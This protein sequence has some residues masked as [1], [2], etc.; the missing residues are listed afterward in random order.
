MK[1][2]FLIGHLLHNGCQ[3]IYFKRKFT[4][5]CF[6][7][8]FLSGLLPLGAQEIPQPVPP[9]PGVAAIEKYGSIP[10]TYY[11]GLPNVS[12]PIYTLS[13]K[14]I[15]VPISI[16][17]HAQGIKVNDI[18]SE[19]GLGWSLNAGGYLTRYQNDHE[20]G[21]GDSGFSSL[22]ELT[23]YLAT[24]DNPDGS[25]SEEIYCGNFRDNDIDLYSFSM[26]TGGGKFFYD[27]ND[28]IRFLPAANYSVLKDNVIGNTLEGYIIRDVNGIDHIYETIE[29]QEQMFTG[30]SLGCKQPNG[31]SETSKLSRM[32]S[33]D[34]GEVNFI[35]D[36]ISYSYLTSYNE[37]KVTIDDPD[38]SISDSYSWNGVDVT[39]GRR[40]KQITTKEGYV[41]DFEYNG[42]ANYSS[43]FGPGK[44]TRISISFQGTE[45]KWFEFTYGTFTSNSANVPNS[46]P[47]H[48][49]S[50][51]HKLLSVE[52]SG[53][54]KFEFDYSNIS[55]PPRFSFAQDYW[56]YYNGAINNTTAIPD[57]PVGGDP[58]NV[59][60]AT[61]DRSSSLLHT[62][63]GV[64]QKIT[65][66]TGGSTAFLYELSHVPHPGTD[67][68]GCVTSYVSKNELHDF[69]SISANC[70]DLIQESFSVTIPSGSKGIKVYYNS[71]IDA[72]SQV[73]CVHN[74]EMNRSILT[75]GATSVPF[76]GTSQV[77]NIPDSF[78]GQLTVDISLNGLINTY[79]IQTTFTVVWQ[80]EVVECP[81]GG[82]PVELN[83]GG[84][85]LKKQVDYAGEGIPMVKNYTYSNPISQYPMF[86]SKRDAYH[87]DPSDGCFLLQN[88]LV[89]VL[90]SNPVVG[91]ST[92]F[93]GSTIYE[94]VTEYLG[95][96]PGNCYQNEELDTVC[97]NPFSKT[98]YIY[99]HEPDHLVIHPQY[100]IGKIVDNSHLR[101]KLLEQK[102]YMYEEASKIFKL[103]SH[104]VNT[105]DTLY[106][107][108]HYG[109]DVSLVRSEYVTG[110]NCVNWP[111]VYDYFVKPYHSEWLELKSYAQTEYFYGET[112][113]F[114]GS[115]TTTTNY[116][117]NSN[118]LPTQVVTHDPVGSSKVNYTYGLVQAKGIPTEVE[119][120][121]DEG[122]EAVNYQLM[123]K[124]EMT[125][126]NVS[127]ILHLTNLKTTRGTDILSNTSV[128]YDSF[129]R[130]ILVT[131][132][133]TG[134]STAYT[135]A[136]DS[137]LYPS[138]KCE[139]CFSVFT[140]GFE[141]HPDS[142]N[143]ANAKTGE[144]I[145]NLADGPVTIV[146]PSYYEITYWKKSSLSSS[147]QK[148]TAA[149]NSG[150]SFTIS[151]TGYIDNVIV[152]PPGGIVTTF[153]VKPGVG[154]TSM[155]DHNGKSAKYEYDEY[156]RLIM[157][158]D[159]DRNI[160]KA[161]QYNYKN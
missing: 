17:Y 18:S 27:N 134:I 63:A 39:D 141:H 154:I 40:I 90:T 32:T 140:E 12:I 136:T 34:G 24:Y 80:E 44:L 61:G 150:G 104:L 124:Q 142:F 146:A 148:S 43:S 68:Q 1:G 159:D 35:Y 45:F 8:L 58:F 131:D 31:V 47:P 84:L 65:Y 22:S 19:T 83:L 119:N 110:S 48:D 4:L 113:S 49:Y 86:Y 59:S 95:D 149:T 153:S 107:Y 85:R 16:S 101:G 20:D 55:L 11:T 46:I 78:S 52:E 126:T 92:L 51:R 98:V 73:D 135:Y 145:Y 30:G 158:L 41:V 105:Y 88:D 94:E 70:A 28:N 160:L 102:Q 161:Y 69:Q 62:Q 53:K 129:N 152:Y 138:A 72:T 137:A 151:G 25:I 120:Y 75:Y 116:T 57:K 132:D 21:A 122:F 133:I 3:P 144:Y 128:S 79:P 6:L 93:G 108:T 99:K 155:T 64:L 112:S 109:I 87:I 121:R 100:G 115:Q 123:S 36:T 127:S 117:H 143:D 97:P 77:V 13:S 147:W 33:F 89:P 76:N 50:G 125:Y 81:T 74:E 56:G 157:Q 82:E 60:F 5:I 14:S 9:S 67:P 42:G 111:A 7:I 114:T 71:D 15:S 106:Q 54:G 37:T 118:L 91:V 66:P 103:K 2:L 10:T 156:G 130:P 26:P 23:S 96:I 29:T 38:L 139:N